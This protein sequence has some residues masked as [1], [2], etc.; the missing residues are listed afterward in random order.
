M[1]DNPTYSNIAKRKLHRTKPN[2]IR[3]FRV[4]RWYK[5]SSPHAHTTAC[6]QRRLTTSNIDLSAALPNTQL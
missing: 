1:Q 2:S 6:L 5:P 4:E 3:L